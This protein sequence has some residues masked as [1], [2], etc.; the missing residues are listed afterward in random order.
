M[1]NALIT[2]G[3]WRA[4]GDGGT[5]TFI[6]VGGS[7]TDALTLDW[8]DLVA[9]AH[10]DDRA[11]LASLPRALLPGHPVSVEFRLAGETEGAWRWLRMT[12]AA[13]GGTGAT[14]VGGII[15]DIT[16]MRE[17]ETRARE[18]ATRVNQFASTV[19]HDLQAPLRHIAIYIDM[20]RTE[21]KEQIPQPQLAMLQIVEDK[22]RGLQSY[23]K[24]VMGLA[25]ESHVPDIGP[26]D[27]DAALRRA[28]VGLWEEA[29][30]CGADISLPPPSHAHV[31]ADGATL[32]TAIAAVL[33]NTLHHRHGGAAKVLVSISR[34][35]GRVQLFIA[36]DGP[37]IPKEISSRIFD[38]FWSNPVGG[39][40][41]RPGMGL[42]L[43]KAI[44]LPLNGDIRLHASGADG[45]TF[46][47]DLPAASAS[48]DESPGS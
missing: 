19:A 9:R 42:A 26:V 27:V 23:V 3:V 16:A 13:S 4:D 36:D 6:P 46:V 20:L 33:S 25:R 37:G 40:P 5:F 34:S 8:A 28:H 48:G 21:L 43:A 24:T 30:D 15:G 31:L 29:E 35:G 7:E 2:D 12:G 10:P 11:G 22:A 41:R 1:Q 17:R 39:N 44:L 18:A 32:S 45:S 47:L 14:G 38:P